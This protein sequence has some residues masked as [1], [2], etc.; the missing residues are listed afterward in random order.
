MNFWKYFTIY[1]RDPAQQS[2][3]VPSNHCQPD[4]WHCGGADDSAALPYL[5]LH[6]IFVLRAINVNR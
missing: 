6:H 3:T 5:C 1:L 2:Q 4:V